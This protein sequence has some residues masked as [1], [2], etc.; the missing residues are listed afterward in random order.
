MKH[1]AVKECA[2]VA[3]PDE[4]RGNI[5]KAFI[6][7]KDGMEAQMSLLRSCSSM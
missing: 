1:S 7:L 5:V 3:S 2:A 4:T 6:V